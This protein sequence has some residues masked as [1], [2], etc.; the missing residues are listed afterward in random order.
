MTHYPGTSKDGALTDLSY[1][2]DLQGREKESEEW[3]VF[4]NFNYLELFN[5]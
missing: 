5:F 1:V 2:D 4:W 3:R